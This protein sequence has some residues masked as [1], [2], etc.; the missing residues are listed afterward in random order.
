MLKEFRKGERLPPLPP[1]GSYRVID[2]RG[3]VV[4]VAIDMPE[5]RLPD[6]RRKLDAHEPYDD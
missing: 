1:G 4:T 6:A 2:V 3:K 5:C